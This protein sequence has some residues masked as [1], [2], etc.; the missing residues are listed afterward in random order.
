MAAGKSEITLT[1]KGKMLVLMTRFAPW[2]F[3]LFA[4]KK[5]RKLFAEEIAARKAGR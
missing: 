5:V 1:A 2:V 3:D 4:K